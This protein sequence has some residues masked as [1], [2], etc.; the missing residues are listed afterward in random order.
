MTGYTKLFNSIVTSTIWSEDD[1]TRIVWITMLAIADKNGEVQGSVPG[2]ARI[3]GVSVDDCRVAI[4]KFLS[5]D[6]DSRTKDDEGRRIEEIDGGWSLLNHQK[7]REM[8][9]KDELREA[10][11]KRKARYREKI[12]R[13]EKSQNVP[14]KSPNVPKSQHIA[15]ANTEENTDTDS[16]TESINIKRTS[17]KKEKPS[18]E[19]PPLPFNSKEFADEW[20][21]FIKF[22]L[23]K[24]KPVSP[25]AAKANFSDF[26][27]WGEARS[28]EAIRNS[29]KNDYQ[30]IFEP[31]QA[32]QSP[33]PSQPRNMDVSGKILP[34]PPSKQY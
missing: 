24:K 28:I 16:N 10:E 31:K 13:N 17:P 23:A 4:A 2:L 21:D 1:K 12:K 9:S 20:N 26:A 3:A 27:K 33:A 5:P 6:P 14:D 7:Y 11:A 29:I 32:Y 22:R 18:E 25:I 30:G 15:E 19:F 34:L 8:A